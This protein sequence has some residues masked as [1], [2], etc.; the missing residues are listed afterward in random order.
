[1]SSS[2]CNTNTTIKVELEIYYV[3]RNLAR[4]LLHSKVL[5]ILGVTMIAG[6]GEERVLGLV[7][8]SLESIATG[9]IGRGENSKEN[10]FRQEQLSLKSFS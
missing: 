1:V 5:I 4:L 9:M 6:V 10:Y 8:A 3:S 2:F 7:P